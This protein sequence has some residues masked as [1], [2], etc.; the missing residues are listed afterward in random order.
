MS[1]TILL[2]NYQF[3]YRSLIS[4]TLYTHIKCTMLLLWVGKYTLVN[5]YVK[6]Y[7]IIWAKTQPAASD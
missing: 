3:K 6:Q 5:M 4:D 7:S 2:F 1:G